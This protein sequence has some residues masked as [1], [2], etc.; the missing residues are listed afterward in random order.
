MSSKEFLG[1]GW[2]FPVNVG[3]DGIFEI[4]KYEEDIEEAIMIILGTSK[5]ERVMRPD[6]GCD[7]HEYVFDVIDM[8]TIGRI[9]SSVIEALTTWE[10][11]IEII[12]LDVSTKDVDNGKLIILLDY[13]ILSTNNRRNF[14]YDFYLKEGI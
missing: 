13:R 2:K 3:K 14:V 12:T 4:S 8:Q 10:P 7:L 5:G 6:F 1:V 11:R 9:K